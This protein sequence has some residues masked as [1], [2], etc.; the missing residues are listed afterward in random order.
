MDAN[1][2][3]II[4]LGLTLA[5]ILLFLTFFS[6]TIYSFNLAGVTADFPTDGVIKRTARAEGTV[7]F[8]DIQYLYANDAG[9]VTFHKKAGDQISQGDALYTLLADTDDLQEQLRAENNRLEK[10]RLD[11]E[12]AETDIAYNQQRLD[13]LTAAGANVTPPDTARY[14][15]EAARLTAEIVQTEADHQSAADLYASGAIPKSDLDELENKLANLR[16]EQ[17]QNDEQ[18][19]RAISEYE[20]TLTQAQAEQH[21]AYE[22]ERS[23]LQKGIGDLRYQLESLALD[24][25]ESRLRLQALEERLAQDGAETFYAENAGVVRETGA[26]D[27]ALVE[28]GR[29]LARI[30]TAAQ[31][32]Y[33]YHAEAVFSDTA[34]FLEA[35]AEV[36]VDLRAARQYGLRGVLTRVG[37]ANGRFSADVAFD[38]PLTLTGGEK[39]EITAEHLSELYGSVLP[40]SAIRKDD[41]GDYILYVERVRN[42]LLGYA[43]Y[44]RRMSVG[45]LEQDDSYTAF[46]MMIET[47]G[48]VII[49]S[50]RPVAE[51]DRVRLVG[52]DELFEIR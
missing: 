27:G 33:P 4:R 3:L 42:T 18:R 29:M 46:Y 39:A 32:G 48:P 20:R 34:D 14:D 17:Q 26:E 36:R 12:K 25:A 52:G 6:N 37:Y 49:N 13:S 38:A 31:G 9:K 2:R 43:Y 45:I 5:G 35:G 40:N 24:D 41:E 1:K 23:A 11:T 28:A 19:A 8:S 22:A 47:E 10:L 15:Y 16:R 30:G 50:D 7:D 51:G 21:R 44:A